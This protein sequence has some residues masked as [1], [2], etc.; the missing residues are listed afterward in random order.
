MTLG[1]EFTAYGSS[2][3]KAKYYIKKSAFELKEIPIGGTAVGTGLHTPKNYKKFVI[4][5][6]RKFT[7]LN[8]IPAKDNF[9]AMQS[10]RAISSVSA[11]LRN[12]SLE[13][14]RIANDLRLL[15]SG[16]ITG[17]AEI[18][19]PSVQAGQ[20]EINVFM[21]VMAFN[22]LFSI[23]ILKK[24]LPVFTKKCVLGITADEKKCKEYF[25]NTSG[26]ATVLNPYIGYLKSAEVM[27]ESLSTGKGIIDVVR[28]RGLLSEEKIREIF[29]INIKI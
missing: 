22:V 13:L 15:S 14:T 26:L 24:F 5:N 8:L 27:K 7:G 29:R 10:R 25:E 1:D 12:L 3:R 28:K 21:P 20:L 18:N 11:S 4:K 9:E 16:P 17:F 6:L 23:D 19:L 2:L